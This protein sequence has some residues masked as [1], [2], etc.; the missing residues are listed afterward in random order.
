MLNGSSSVN[1]LFQN[2]T[3]SVSI[4]QNDLPDSSVALLKQSTVGSKTDDC[5][6]PMMQQKGSAR[7]IKKVFFS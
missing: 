4:T 2:E 5:V 6:T 7:L 1:E 3:A